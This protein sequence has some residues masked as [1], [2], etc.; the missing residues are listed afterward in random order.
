MWLNNLLNTPSEQHHVLREQAWAWANQLAGAKTVALWFDDGALFCT[1]LMASWQAGAEVWLLPNTHEHALAWGAQADVLLSDV[2]F[3]LQNY[4]AFTAQSPL[5]TIPSWHISEQARVKLH[6]SGSTGD[7]KIITKTAQQMCAEAEA[8]ADVL[9]HAWQNLPVYAS[10]LPQHLYGLTFRVF[11]A[12]KMG[13]AVHSTL[14]RY[15]EDFVAMS[16]QASLWLTSPTVLT[17][18]GEQRDWARLRG[19]VQGIISAGGALPEQT[20]QLFKQYLQLPIMD[21]YGSTETGVVAKRWGTLH[22]TLFPQVRAR[23]DEN[24]RLHI[25]SPWVEE[26]QMLADCAEW[27]GDELVLHGRSDRIIKLADKRISLNRI[28]HDLLAHEWVADVHCSLQRERVGAWVALNDAGIDFLRQHGR[29]AV[30]ARLRQSLVSSTEKVALPRYWRFMAHT[31]P[32]NA[33]SKIRANDVNQAFAMQPSRPDWQLVHQQEHEWRF[34][35]R[36]PVDLRYFSGHFAEFPLVAGVVQMQWAMDLA[37]QFEWG[38]RP[39]RQMENLKYQHF[40]RPNDAVELSLRWDAEK[41]KIHFHLQV[42][43]KVC[44]SGRAVM[45]CP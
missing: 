19:Q 2:P 27:Q 45:L 43:G 18:F 1:A 16:K 34:M 36:V 35:G 12:W 37:K 4:R 11:V 8:I 20:M 44:A 25:A 32:R 28:E 29:G 40:I 31:L 13:W 42:D 7:A 17:H 30:V 39:V 33:Q 10:V 6:T 21:V 23:L 15:P 5:S 9:P 26:E 14:C 22:H 41:G 38:N 24:Q 3:S